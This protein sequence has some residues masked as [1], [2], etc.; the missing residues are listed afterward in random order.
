MDHYL[1]Q[2]LQNQVSWIID[3]ELTW[4]LKILLMFVQTEK[5]HAQIERAKLHKKNPGINE[6]LDMKVPSSYLLLQRSEI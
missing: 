1:M 5:T 3:Y 4:P 2:F 6:V